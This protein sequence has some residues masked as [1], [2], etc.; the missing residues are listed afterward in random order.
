LYPAAANSKHW[1]KRIGCIRLGATRTRD[2][3]GR[4]AK[5]VDLV[6]ESFQ[7]LGRRLALAAEPG[8]ESAMEGA[9]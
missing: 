2:I 8:A 3:D 5:Q 6:V 1:P 4:R 7:L 9:T